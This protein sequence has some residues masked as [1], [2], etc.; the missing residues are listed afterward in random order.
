MSGTEKTAPTLLEDLAAIDPA[1][2]RKV[3][4]RA[5]YRYVA[6]VNAKSVELQ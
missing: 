2:R 1:Q 4:R 3:G 6:A 5:R